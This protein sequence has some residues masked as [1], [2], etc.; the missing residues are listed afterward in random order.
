MCQN[1]V[2]KK[3]YRSFT[4]PQNLDD[5]LTFGEY[6][7]TTSAVQKQNSSPGRN[8]AASSPVLHGGTLMAHASCLNGA[9][10]NGLSRMASLAASNMAPM[11]GM[12]LFFRPRGREPWM[13][14][15]AKGTGAVM[16]VAR[17]D[18]QSWKREGV[19]TQDKVFPSSLYVY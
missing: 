12:L 17:P 6:D 2:T 7:G 5:L 8:A 14:V 3:D 19:G 1:H 16:P 15:W 11:T 18:R 4:T 9:S 13:V 10:Q